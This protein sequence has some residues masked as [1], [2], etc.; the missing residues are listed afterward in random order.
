VSS[1][2]SSE[3]QELNIKFF[4]LM[5]AYSEIMASCGNDASKTVISGKFSVSFT[6]SRILK[7]IDALLDVFNIQVALIN[8]EEN[9]IFD[10]HIENLNKIQS[11]LTKSG[12]IK[13]S[14]VSTAVFAGILALVPVLSGIMNFNSAINWAINETSKFLPWAT[15]TKFSSLYL[16]IFL[17]YILVYPF[18][19][20]LFFGYKRSKHYFK[21]SDAV[22]KEE[23][24]FNAIHEYVKSEQKRAD[25]AIP[26]AS[27]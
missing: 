15:H 12:L 9:K 23:A 8:N 3:L 16:F 19:T 20:F 24:L 6:K 14:S 18:I 1:T 10:K 17:F 22:N 11:E 27:K 26:E 25:N 4:D 5:S 13:L 21:N 2:N 7:T